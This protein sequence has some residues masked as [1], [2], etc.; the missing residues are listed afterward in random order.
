LG[1][2]SQSSALYFQIIILE[3]KAGENQQE[4]ADLVKAIFLERYFGTNSRL[5]KFVEQLLLK[6][7]RS[8]A[9]EINKAIKVL[10]T[11]ASA[12]IIDNIKEKYGFELY[13]KKSDGS[14]KWADPFERFL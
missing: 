2:L 8:I 13:G 1:K 11:N 6:G 7:H 3:S 4:I 10:G 14:Y 5:H 9:R 12:N